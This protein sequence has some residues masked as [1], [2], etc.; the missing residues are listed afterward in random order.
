MQIGEEVRPVGPGDAIAIPP[1]A[2]H[3]ITNTGPNILKFLCLL[4]SRL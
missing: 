4:R 1:K 2:L 3:R